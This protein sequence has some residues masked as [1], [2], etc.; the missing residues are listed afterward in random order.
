M[1]AVYITTAI[2]FVSDVRGRPIY[3]FTVRDREKAH[4]LEKAVDE[5]YSPDDKPLLSP[6]RRVAVVDD[7]VTGGGS[8]L[9][10]VDAVSEEGCEIVAVIAIVDRN[11]GGRERLADRGLPYVSLFEADPKGNLGICSEFASRG[12][13]AARAD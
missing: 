10:A 5:S 13:V 6:G 9:K 3:G 4:G 12:A 7:V 1:G 8:I 2:V 11:Q